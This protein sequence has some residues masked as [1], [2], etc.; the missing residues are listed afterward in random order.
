MRLLYATEARPDAYLIQA[1][2]EAG[3]V[4]ETAGDPADGLAWPRAATTTP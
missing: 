3:H 1:L 4:T 2:R